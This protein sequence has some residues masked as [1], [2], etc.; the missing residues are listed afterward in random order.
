MILL[1]NMYISAI[2]EDMVISI[3]K[4]FMKRDEDY[5]V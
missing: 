1:M 5:N 3:Y 2:F 4:S